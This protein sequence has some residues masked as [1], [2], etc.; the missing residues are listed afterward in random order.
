MVRAHRGC[1]LQRVRVARAIIPRSAAV[2]TAPANPTLLAQP[3]GLPL[4]ANQGSRPPPPGRRAEAIPAPPWGD[5]RRPAHLPSLEKY[6]SL[7][8][9]PRDLGDES[10]QAIIDVHPPL[11]P[12][13][14]TVR[15][16]PIGQSSKGDRF[17][18]MRAE[19]EQGSFS[20]MLMMAPG[21][22]S[23]RYPPALGNP[24][25]ACASLPSSTAPSHLPRVT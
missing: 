19:L 23:V 16:R 17:V 1:D 4:W 15:D 22:G 3:L 11:R 5:A 2:S 24:M 10:L 9:P 18:W 6:S 14:F 8:S 13:H 20:E 12:R 21:F 7:A 25:Y